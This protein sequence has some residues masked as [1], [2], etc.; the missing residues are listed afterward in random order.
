MQG[1]A[2]VKFGNLLLL[3]AFAAVPASAGEIEFEGRTVE[4]G[5]GQE[6]PAILRMSG[7][8]YGIN[9]TSVQIL[10]KARAC[11]SRIEGVSVA[12]VEAGTLTAD[13]R[14]DFRA[15]FSSHSIRSKLA[16]AATDGY[17]S[18]SQSALAYSPAP[19]AET[20][21]DGYTALVHDGGDWDNALETAV[22]LEDGLVDCMYR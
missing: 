15:M 20:P 9:A 14:A 10:D 7:A 13:V 21:D 3:A 2:V 1:G 17:F 11:I 6:S 22:K 19:A 16:L 8:R 5:D 12:S 4:I 18:I